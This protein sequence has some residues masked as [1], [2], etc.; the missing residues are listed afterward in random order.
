MAAGLSCLIMDPA[1]DCAPASSGAGQL[2]RT[3]HF[4]VPGH[5]GSTPQQRR[6]AAIIDVRIKP[7]SDGVYQQA[8]HTRHM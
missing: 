7:A 5:A 1:N 4:A 2:I 8:S 6:S 3:W